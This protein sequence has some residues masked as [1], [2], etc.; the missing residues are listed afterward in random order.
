MGFYAG[1][2]RLMERDE[3][4]GLLRQHVADV[5]RFGVSS[6]AVFGS[7]AREE[8]DARSDVDMVVEFAGPPTFDG[9]MGLKFYLEDLLG[10]PVDLVTRDSLKPRLKAVVEGEAI[11]VA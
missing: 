7:V 9:Y 4:I 10:C 5:Q 1:R 3:T 8:A 11:R 6:L 2:L